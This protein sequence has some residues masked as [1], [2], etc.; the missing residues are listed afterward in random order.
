MNYKANIFIKKQLFLLFLIEYI[1]LSSIIVSKNIK[2]N[3]LTSLKLIK[4][5]YIYI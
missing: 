5:L 1:F 3:T 4:K 2:S